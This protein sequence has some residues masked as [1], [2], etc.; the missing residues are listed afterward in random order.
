MAHLADQDFGQILGFKR[1]GP[2]QQAAQQ[3]E[4]ARPGVAAFDSGDFAQ[5][6]IDL[7][8]S[9]G[10]IGFGGPQAHHDFHRVAKI[11]RFGKDV[12]AALHRIGYFRGDSPDCPSADVELGLI[13]DRQGPS[14]HEPRRGV[15]LFDTERGEEISGQLRH[16][17]TALG[18]AQRLTNL[19]KL[20]KAGHVMI[21]SASV[22]VCF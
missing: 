17:E 7:R 10:R 21:L 11:D 2:R 14:D 13:A 12:L 6:K 5:S 9:E 22:S 8:N 15:G 1:G 20:I 18:L 16:L 3:V 4:L 19:G